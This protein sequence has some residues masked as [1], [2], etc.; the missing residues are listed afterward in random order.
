MKLK[1]L[2]RHVLSKIWARGKS[3]KL[4]ELFRTSGIA[5]PDFMDS[6]IEASA[7][8][9]KSYDDG[10]VGYPEDPEADKELAEAL[11]L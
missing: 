3:E 6:D 11:G 2:P 1:D 8:S 4:A 9:V 5:D 10:P 7:G